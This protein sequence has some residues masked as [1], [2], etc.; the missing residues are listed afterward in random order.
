M[1][2]RETLS[3]KPA[4][5]FA[6]RIAE[7]PSASNPAGHRPV[8]QRNFR[9]LASTTITAPHF[10]ARSSKAL[11][12]G[13]SDPMTVE[14]R[15]PVERVFLAI[16]GDRFPGLDFTIVRPGKRRLGLH[17]RAPGDD[18]ALILGGGVAWPARVLGRV[19]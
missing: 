13:Q 14:G 16:L 8:E 18:L 1:T 19:A 4:L 2:G 17:G 5:P 6:R 10:G 7:L 15:S 11:V 3:A 12:G 9:R